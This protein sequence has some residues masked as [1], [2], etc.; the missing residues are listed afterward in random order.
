MIQAKLL[1]SPPFIKINAC[2]I[3]Y[4]LWLIFSQNMIITETTSSSV[5]FYN[6]PE[7]YI[8]SA[9]TTIQIILSGPKKI[10]QLSQAYN[11]TIHIDASNLNLG[12]NF[13]KLCKENIFLPDSINLVNLMPTQIEIQLQ[14]IE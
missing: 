4:G 13:V 3:G 5:Y 7:D 6:I 12:K 1:L 14:K 10:M 9:P 8:V 2:L 11:S